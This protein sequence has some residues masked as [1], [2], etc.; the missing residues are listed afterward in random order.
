MRYTYSRWTG[1]ELGA[2]DADDLMAA[3]SDDLMA[4]G[5]IDSALQ[6]I[7]RWG[8]QIRGENRAQGVQGLM[9]QLRDKRERELERYHL[10]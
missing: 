6:R 2:V 1:S 8:L 5:N 7:T 9:Q 10:D 3:L 4:D